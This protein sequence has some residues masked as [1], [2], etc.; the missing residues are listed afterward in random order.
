MLMSPSALGAQKGGRISYLE[1]LKIGYA[2][3]RAKEAIIKERCG[4]ALPTSC[5]DRRA[6]DEMLLFVGLRRAAR[7]FAATK[8]SRPRFAR[9]RL[10]RCVPSVLCL[11]VPSDVS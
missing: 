2:C 8:R 10:Q 4:P 3:L 6:D 9:G 11:A 1:L 7:T 5:R